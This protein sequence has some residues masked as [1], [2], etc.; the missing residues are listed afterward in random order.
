MDFT[1]QIT[2]KDG[3][4]RSATGQLQFLVGDEAA[5]TSPTGRWEVWGPTA[6]AIG[7]VVVAAL[8]TIRRILRR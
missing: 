8:V 1:A 7:L 5:V 4:R 6:L 3:S 2:E